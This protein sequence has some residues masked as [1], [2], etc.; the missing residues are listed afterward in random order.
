MGKPKEVKAPKV[1]DPIAQVVTG[2]QAGDAEVKRR[3]RAGG[4]KRNVLAGQL[5]PSTGKSSVLG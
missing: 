2:D 4:F 1:P 5:T 3:S